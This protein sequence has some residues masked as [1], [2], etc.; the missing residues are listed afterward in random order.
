[1]IEVSRVSP[2]RSSYRPFPLWVGAIVSVLAWAALT[3]VPAAYAEKQNT[4]AGS[5]TADKTDKTK[6]APVLTEDNEVKIGR[7]NAEDNDKH[8]RLVTDAALLERVN[9]IGQEIAAVANKTS[10]PALW[11]SSQLKQFNY[12][13]KIVDDKDVNAYSLPGGFIYINKGLLD[14]VHSDD[15]LAGVLAHEISH[16]SH[17]H[18]VKLMREQSKIQNVLLPALAAAIILSHSSAADLGNLVITS[19][20]YTVAKLNTYG[21]EAEKDADH[22]G[23]LLLTYTKYRPAG[24]YSFML[25]LAADERNHTYGDMGIFRTHPAGADRVAAAK[26]LLDELK[27][28]IKLSDV[29]PMQKV[30]VTLIKGGGANG[31]DVAELKMR[32]LPLFRVIAADDLTAEERGQQ[33]AKQLNE[34]FDTGLQPWQV[35]LNPAKNRVLVR[36]ITMLSEQDAQAQGKSLK[37]LADQMCDTIGQVGLKRQIEDV[38]K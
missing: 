9:R 17:H 15:E 11:G 3:S 10:I 36:G 12:T 2:R 30:M 25:R 22:S 16:A 34:M 37:D 5:K 4:P 24:L 1:M 28:A 14:Y 33:I 19:Q 6:S 23:L 8:V 7:E 27:I 18:M 20:L 38:S 31:R 32:G 35:R 26:K 13:F 29:D 21:I